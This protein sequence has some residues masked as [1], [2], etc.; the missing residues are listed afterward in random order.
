MAKISSETL[1]AYADGELHGGDKILVEEALKKDA[2]LRDQLSRHYAL[3]AELA[4]AF[5]EI[6]EVPMPADILGMLQEDSP[7]SS[8]KDNT[9]VSLTPPPVVHT[10]PSWQPAALAA[11]VAVA[12]LAGM[13]VDGDGGDRGQKA[14]F[15]VSADLGTMLDHAAS[16]T[17]AGGYKVEASFLDVVGTFCRSFTAA[18]TGGEQQGLS[19]RNAQGVWTLS[20][21]TPTLPA[22]AYLPASGDTG[23]L[24]EQSTAAMRKL[25]ISDERDYL[26]SD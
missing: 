16:G 14:A 25:S 6:D 4:M 10:R 24:I 21:L 20:V 2:D 18:K 5:K 22:K 19:C 9:V 17:E 13:M 15:T 26:S 3:K 8:P 23:G 11:S 7:Q 1:M 12:F